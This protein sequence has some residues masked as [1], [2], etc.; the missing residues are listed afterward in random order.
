VAVSPAEFALGIEDVAVEPDIRLGQPVAA[1][2]RVGQEREGESD[3]IRSASTFVPVSVVTVRTSAIA[4]TR[5][6]MSPPI[7][8]DCT[9]HL[10]ST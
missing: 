7:Q 3:S 6:R 9:E 2:A 5:I 1:G 8:S 4:P 10:L